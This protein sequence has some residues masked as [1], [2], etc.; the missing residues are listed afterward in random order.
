MRYATYSCLWQ[1]IYSIQY[2]QRSPL[3]NN[4]GWKGKTPRECID[5][6]EHGLYDIGIDLGAVLSDLMSSPGSR[7]GPRPSTV[8]KSQDFPTLITRMVELHSALKD[9]WHSL[10]AWA[11]KPLYWQ[12]Q[13]RDTEQAPEHAALG[14]SHLHVPDSVLVY[15]D[16]RL[17]HLC[18]DYWAVYL[19]L[20]VVMMRTLE[21][22]PTP[23][24]AMPVMQIFVAMAQRH[25]ENFQ[26]GMATNI[27]NSVSYTRR[28]DMGYVGAQRSMFPIRMALSAFRS[29]P[30]PYPESQARIVAQMLRRMSV[31]W[32][33]RFAEDLESRKVDL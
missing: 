31:D 20:C 32:G 23:I 19:V 14:A 12:Q 24:K 10:V 16:L 4:P 6:Y 17:A 13:P 5:D 28:P 15:Q 29:L 11:P 18:M 21:Q 2:R 1:M 26:L 27:V 9:W 8:Q 22:I 25:G 33:L 7:E 30:G 3:V